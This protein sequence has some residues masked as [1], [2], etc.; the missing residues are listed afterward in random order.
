MFSCECGQW[1]CG[2]C[3]PHLQS[4]EKRDRLIAESER[5]RRAKTLK[6]CDKTI[7]PFGKHKG[8][9]ISALDSKYCYWL[10][11]YQRKT[12]QK[13]LLELLEFRAQYYSVPRRTSSFY[14][15]DDFD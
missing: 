13:D 5:K 12:L 15:D 3:R 9:K 11:H 6:K 4:I 10:V 7:M 8:E 14:F 2:Y 1:N